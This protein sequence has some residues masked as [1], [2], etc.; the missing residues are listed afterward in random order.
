MLEAAD[1]VDYS[2]H[3]AHRVNLQEVNWCDL[4][5]AGSYVAVETGNL[6]RFP[7]KALISGISPI[8]TLESRGGTRLVKLSSDPYEI[9]P[10][11]RVLAAQIGVKL[12]F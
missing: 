11:L 10:K 7:Q 8:I 9:S 5:D 1:R 2:I 4:R 12:N 3:P 6:F